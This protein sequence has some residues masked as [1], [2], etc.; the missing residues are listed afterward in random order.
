MVFIF[1]FKFHCKKKNQKK[2]FLCCFNYLDSV[3]SAMLRKFTVTTSKSAQIFTRARRK[4]PGGVNSPVRAWKAVGGIPRIISRGSGAH[5]FDVDKNKY[6]DFVGSWEPFILGHAHPKIV[7]AIQRSAQS[8]TTFGA[9]TEREVE[10]A[11]AFR[12]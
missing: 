8:G 6:I 7:A 11:N 10:L 1:L 4:I 9:P 12:V 2:K 5:I 3:V